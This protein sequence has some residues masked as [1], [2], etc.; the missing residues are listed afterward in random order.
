MLIRHIIGVELEKEK[1]NTSEDFFNRSETVYEVNGEDH[2]FHLLY[3]RY[4]EEKL[5]EELTQ[6]TFWKSYLKRYKIREI[7]SLA[8]LCKNKSYQNR[9]RVYINQFEDFRSLFIDTDK[10]SFQSFLTKFE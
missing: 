4:F 8:A 3:V 5:E 2:I 9:K 7:A 6:H 1:P 10:E